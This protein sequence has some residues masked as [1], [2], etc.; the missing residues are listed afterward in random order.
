[1]IA[2]LPAAGKASPQ[3]PELGSRRISCSAPVAYRRQSTA[4]RDSV[5]P[6]ALQLYFYATRIHL[7]PVDGDL[8]RSIAEVAFELT[9]SIAPGVVPQTEELY[10]EL[11]GSP[12]M[13]MHVAQQVVLLT[14]HYKAQP[15]RPGAPRSIERL[16]RSGIARATDRVMRNRDLLKTI[17]QSAQYRKKY[18]ED[19]NQLAGPVA[20]K[21]MR[22]PD[23]PVTSR[24][25]AGGMFSLAGFG[26]P[27][28]AYPL[29]F[30]YTVQFYNESGASHGPAATV[31]V[32][33]KL[34]GLVDPGTLA[35]GQITFEKEGNAGARVLCQVTPPGPPVSGQTFIVPPV[36]GQPAGGAPVKVT[37]ERVNRLIRWTLKG[38]LPPGAAGSVSFTVYPKHPSSIPPTANIENAGATV[39]F[40]PVDPAGPPNHRTN[41]WP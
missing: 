7:S 14:A 18:P 25:G 19:P 1:L 13:L 27:P 39:T 11:Y 34:N 4:F 31:I 9:H 2:L 40:L 24:F 26:A 17:R 21:P 10:F 38:V 12:G 41:D 3:N 29:P 28:V 8:T 32:E 22:L 36:P 6:L 15:S 16:V 35:L 20:L 37:F 5:K 23:Q 33:D 30:I